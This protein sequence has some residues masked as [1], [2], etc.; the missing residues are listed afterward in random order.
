MHVGSSE[1]N[2]EVFI[3]SRCGSIN[4]I[5]TSLI[6]LMH[7]TRIPMMFLRFLRRYDDL[8]KLIMGWASGSFME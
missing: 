4:D 2:L 6:S 1:R 3:I 7:A 5:I 8:M